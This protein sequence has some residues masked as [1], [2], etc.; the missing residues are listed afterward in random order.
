MTV[1]TQSS[2]SCSNV[3]MPV[4]PGMVGRNRRN[5]KSLS[6]AEASP[7]PSPVAARSPANLRRMSLKL[8]YDSF[9]SLEHAKSACMRLHM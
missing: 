6:A 3:W 4:T 9:H 5:T 7:S 2:K 1:K 8:V